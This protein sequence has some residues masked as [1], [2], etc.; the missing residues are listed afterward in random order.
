[1]EASELAMKMKL[2]IGEFG[3]RGEGHIEWSAN[4]EKEDYH[5]HKSFKRKE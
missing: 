4:G 1:M 3:R 5:K 2:E